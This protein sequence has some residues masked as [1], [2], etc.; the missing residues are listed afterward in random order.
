LPDAIERAMDEAGFQ[1]AH[2]VGNSLG[3]HV[4]LALAARAVGRGVRPGGRLGAGRSLARRDAQ[5][6]A[7][8]APRSAV[9]RALRRCDRRHTRGAPARRVTLPIAVDFER[10][11]AE[12]L[13]HQI[14]GAAACDAEP[15]LDYASGADWRIDAERIACPVRIVWGSADRLL[16]WPSAAARFRNDW[17]PHADWVELDGVGHCPQLEVPLEAAALITG[18]T[19]GSRRRDARRSTRAHRC[20]AEPEALHDVPPAVVAL[21]HQPGLAGLGSERELRLER[22]SQLLEVDLADGDGEMG[23]DLAVGPGVGRVLWPAPPDRLG[24][25]HERPG[26]QRLEIHGVLETLDAREA[27]ADRRRRR[28]QLRQRVELLA[29][30]PVTFDE[31]PEHRDVRGHTEA[32][33]RIKPRAVGTDERLG[34]RHWEDQM[35][36]AHDRVHRPRRLGARPPCRDGGRS[37]RCERAARGRCLDRSAQPA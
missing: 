3:G 9:A 24:E 1:T 19:A 37:L 35:G 36:F 13:A 23:N 10:I 32:S 22:R 20:P 33:V 8:D 28:E 16:P 7:A 5:L 6:P 21:G 12:L 31:R 34:G 2:I 17:L 30:Q 15:L 29:S 26:R 25:R 4:A 11:P 18:F 27:E 14:C